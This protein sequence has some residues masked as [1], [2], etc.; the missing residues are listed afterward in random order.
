MMYWV[1]VCWAF[2]DRTSTRVRW[3]KYFPLELFGTFTEKMTRGLRLFLYS[4]YFSGDRVSCYTD[5]P[6]DIQE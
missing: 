4:T 5:E 2:S 3:E 1:K 6:N